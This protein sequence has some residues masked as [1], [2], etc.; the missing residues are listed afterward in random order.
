MKSKENNYNIIRFVSAL[1]VIYGHMYVLLGQRAPVLFSNEI[2]AIGFK[3]LMVLSGYMITTSYL[4]DSKLKN[5][6]VKRCFRIFPAL[7]F[8]TLI[9]V[10]FIGPIVSVY[11][12]KEYYESPATWEYLKNILLYPVFALTGLFENNPYP[13]AVN[14]SI[15]AL[16]VEFSLYIF[17]Y[18][19]LSI[20]SKDKIR[21][22]AWFIIAIT[23]CILQLVHLKYYPNKFFVLAGTDWLSALNIYP[24]FM[25][26]GIYSIVNIRKYCNL[27]LASLAIL[28]ASSL[29]F[30][31]MWKMELILMLVLP[32][33]II[34]LGET[35]EPIFSKYFK[36]IDL[37]YGLFL[38]GFPIQQ[39]I[40]KIVLVDRNTVLSPNIFFALS[41]ISTLGFAVITWY[42]IEKPM[43][44]IMKKL[45]T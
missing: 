30:D 40:I 26:G 17:M 23:I 4:K 32:Y 12:V 33:F 29:S 8:Y 10:L 25:I 45:L 20:F 2:N 31:S 44:K 16:P 42:V 11:G 1:M 18:I 3:I 41:L 43:S 19:I 34:S 5:Y 13:G 24:Y 7:I 14:G 39:L 6:A 28:I 38:W 35:K 21:R 36:R 37:S 22:N 15:W 27:Q 9:M